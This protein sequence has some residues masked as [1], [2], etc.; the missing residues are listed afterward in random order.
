VTDKGREGGKAASPRGGR[1]WRPKVTAI[2]PC[3]NAAAFL[4]RT[5]YCLSAQTWPDLEILIGDDCSTDATLEVVH[6]FAAT[7]RNVRVVTRGTNLGWLRNTNDLMAQAAG[8]L[9]FFAFHDDVVDPTYVEKLVEAL[10][11]RPNAILAFSDMEVVGFTAEDSV[12]VWTYDALSGVT[13]SLSRGLVMGR[14]AWCWWVP[15]RGLFRAEAFRRIGGIKPNDCGE[16][17]A[18]W[19]WL[20][21]MALLGDFVRVPDILCRKYYMKGSLSR[22]WAN[23]LEQRAA[24]LRAG[25]RE[26]RESALPLHEKLILMAHLKWRHRIP[27]APRAAVKRVLGIKI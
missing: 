1:N 21:H 8:E 27:K 23:T 18:D 4:D 16:Y 10:R 6:A 19:T 17:S 3:Y 11:D 13:G 25:I 7:H 14:N 9:L 20:L 26:V 5:L 24:L 22:R 2:V 15:N 12:D